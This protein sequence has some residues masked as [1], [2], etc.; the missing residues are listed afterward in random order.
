MCLFLQGLYCLENFEALFRP[1][2][3]DETKFSLMHWS[4]FMLKNRLYIKVCFVR[5]GSRESPVDILEPGRCLH[6]LL[7]PPVALLPCCLRLPKL[8]GQ[9][10]WEFNLHIPTV[11]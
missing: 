6:A 3:V 8:P 4:E 2:N 7:L 10:E 1:L 9:R 5:N 11:L